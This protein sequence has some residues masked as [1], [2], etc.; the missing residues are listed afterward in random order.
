MIAVAM[1]ARAWDERG[2]SLEE[3]PGREV[4]RGAP[5]R[6]GSR[7]C[8]EQTGY[9]AVGPAAA[10]WFNT[11]STQLTFNSG[12]GGF[13]SNDTNSCAAGGGGGGGWG[14]GGGGDNGNNNAAANGGGGSFASASTCL[15]T[16]SPTT[17]QGSPGSSG[18]VFLVFNTQGVWQ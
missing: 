3:L 16:D 9:F 17:Y 8:V 10:R 5:V 15:D 11:G 12:S 4:Q 6:Q 18:N 7:W 2:E 13:G 1:L 14:G